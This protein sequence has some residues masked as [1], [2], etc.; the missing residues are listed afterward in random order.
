MDDQSASNEIL[1]QVELTPSDASTKKQELICRCKAPILKA[2]GR[3]T[4]R[5]ISQMYH[6]KRC[7][8][9][10]IIPAY[11]A[12]VAENG[13]T[14]FERN[15]EGYG[16]AS[17]C[18]KVEGM[19]EFHMDSIGEDIRVSPQEV[20]FRRD[21]PDESIDTKYRNTGF[22][23]GRPFFKFGNLC[24]N[25]G[26]CQLYHTYPERRCGPYQ[27]WRCFRKIY[28]LSKTTTGDELYSALY[29]TCKHKPMC[30]STSVNDIRS[31]AEER[32]N[33]LKAI[34]ANDAQGSGSGSTDSSRGRVEVSEGCAPLLVTR[35]VPP[36]TDDNAGADPSGLG[37]ETEAYTDPAFWDQISGNMNGKTKHGKH[38][39]LLGL[40][41][42]PRMKGYVDA[43]EMGSHVYVPFF[44]MNVQDS[45]E[46]QDPRFLG[47]T[48][49][50]TE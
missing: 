16:V 30:F 41:S 4:Y 25:R 44:G 40:V 13:K 42:D 17:R 14:P 2:D 20:V 43:L 8:R 7:F 9:N 15:F 31:Y 35:D 29:E 19:V 10:V 23:A 27:R 12:L 24:G 33:T 46:D 49:D 28:S 36:S 5:K 3:L 48:R 18:F 45:D 26:C 50:K 39:V 22:M 1:N 32:H 37:A 6:G 47:V 11:E 34:K 38:G 21:N